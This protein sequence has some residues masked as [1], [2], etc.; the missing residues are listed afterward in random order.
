MEIYFK[1]LKNHLGNLFPKI[2]FSK[3]KYDSCRNTCVL[4][5]I[6]TKPLAIS[7]N[8]P[9]EFKSFSASPV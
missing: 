4:S 5:Y 3:I 2:G 1:I 6:K 8:V 9:F 7:Q